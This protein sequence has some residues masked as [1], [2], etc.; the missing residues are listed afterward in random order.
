MDAHRRRNFVGGNRPQSV[1]IRVV[2]VVRQAIYHELRDARRDLP[3]GL[4]LKSEDPGRI[5]TRR[6]DFFL[7]RSA[8]DELHE[9]LHDLPHGWR[10][11]IC[12]H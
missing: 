3:G 8:F 11:H 2:V 6:C 7:G 1:P 12:A 5:V 9:L 10:G 4:E